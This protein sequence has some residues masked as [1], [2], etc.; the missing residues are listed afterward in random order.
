MMTTNLNLSSLKENMMDSLSERTPSETK[1]KPMANIKIIENRIIIGDQEFVLEKKLIKKLDRVV[2]GITQDHPKE[3]AVLIN[4]GKEG[5]GKTNSSVVEALYVKIKTKR[6]VHLFFRLQQLIEF[7]QSTKEKIIIWDEPALDSLSTEQLNKLNKDML[8]LFMTI[9]KKRHFII[10]N[11][12]KFWKFPEYLIVDRSVG[13]IHMKEKEIGRFLYIR[14]KK[15]EFLWNEYRF[16]HKRSY[17]KVMDFGGRMPNIMEKNFDKLGFHVNNIA[18]ASYQDYEDCK[19]E[20]IGSIGKNDA[21]LDKNKLKLDLLR[22]RISH[23]K[24]ITQGDMARMLSVHP[25]RLQ[26]WK[27]LQPPT[28]A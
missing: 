2:K 6:E 12:V 5:K 25:T 13:L 9:R 24:G 1:N 19:D 14:K 4:E 7:A 23:V 16:K 20:A 3:D 11:Y 27:K 26:E 22:Y 17:L 18:N 28:T 10:I 15:L 8:R 21:K